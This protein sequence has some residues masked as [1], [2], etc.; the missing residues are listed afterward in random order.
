MTPKAPD[1]FTYINRLMQAGLDEVQA[2]AIT[3][4]LERAL[5]AEVL[6]AVAELRALP[7][8]SIRSFVRRLLR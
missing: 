7:R 4:R 3:D 8:F 1:K 6:T 2:R 5:S